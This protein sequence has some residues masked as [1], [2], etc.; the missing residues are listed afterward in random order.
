MNM[1]FAVIFYFIKKMRLYYVSIH[2]NFY[3]NQ[4]KNEYARNKKKAQIPEFQSLAVFSEI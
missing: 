3:Q 1:I 2:R 4:F